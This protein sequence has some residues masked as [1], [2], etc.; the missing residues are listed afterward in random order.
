MAIKALEYSSGGEIF[1]PKL[2]SYKIV[3]I[4]EAISK[5]EK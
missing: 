5:M 1:I 3:D 4:V 2:K